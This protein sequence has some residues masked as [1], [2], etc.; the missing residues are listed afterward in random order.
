M[1]INPYLEP[2]PFVNII[3]LIPKGVGSPTCPMFSRSF[4]LFAKIAYA[5]L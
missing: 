4:V 1:S 2:N 3:C 5:F